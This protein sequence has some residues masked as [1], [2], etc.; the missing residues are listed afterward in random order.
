M[1]Y[2][3][4]HADISTLEGEMSHILRAH[5]TITG[6]RKRLLQPVSSKNCVSIVSSNDEDNNTR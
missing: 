3:N 6:I 5:A 4:M 1:N 2:S